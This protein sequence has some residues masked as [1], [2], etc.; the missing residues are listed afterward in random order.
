MTE[1]P[2]KLAGHSQLNGMHHTTWMGQI[3][4]K[5]KLCAVGVPLGRGNTAIYWFLNMTQIPSS[6]CLWNFPLLYWAPCKNGISIFIIR[7]CSTNGVGRNFYT[8]R[9]FKSMSNSNAISST[10]IYEIKKI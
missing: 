3:S 5:S 9:F 6:V 8:Y 2:V 4:K 1:Y 10:T 7:V